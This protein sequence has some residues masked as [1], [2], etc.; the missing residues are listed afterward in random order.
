MGK[1]IIAA[2]FCRIFKQDAISAPFKHRICAQFICHSRRL[3]IGRAQ[4]CKQKRRS[5]LPHG[6]ESATAETTVGPYLAGC[7]NGRPIGNRN[8][9]EYFRKEGRDELRR[10]VCAAYDR[11]AARYNPV[12]LE[13]AGSISEINLRDTDLVNLPMALHAGADVILV[14]TLTVVVCLPVSMV[15]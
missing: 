8:A 10:E 13:G 3:E 5:A 12:V 2:A 1:S 6:H 14:G 7:L 4:L 15:R 11:L 9:Y